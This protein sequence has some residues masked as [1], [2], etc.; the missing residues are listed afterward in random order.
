MSDERFNADLDRIVAAA[1]ELLR[2]ELTYER[3]LR[4]YFADLASATSDIWSIDGV[5]LTHVK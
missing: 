4:E 1:G 5:H 3:A 2:G